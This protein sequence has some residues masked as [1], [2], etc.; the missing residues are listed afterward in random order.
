MPK[1][2]VIVP[3]YNTEKYLRECINSI[4]A[5]TFTDFELI[6]V[7]DGST[8]G[9][10][11][12]CDEYAGKDNRIRVIHQENGGVT[13]ARKNGAVHAKS[14]Y[15]TY[16]DS[17]DWIDPE[18][19]HDLMLHLETQ[20]ADM[21]IFAMVLERKQPV[22][23][24][25]YVEN[26]FYSKESLRKTV[27]PNMLFDY[28]LNCSGVIASLC[29]KIIRRDILFEAIM[30][31]PDSL[32]YGEDAVAGYMCVLNAASIYFCNKPYY[33]YRENLTSISHAEHSVMAARI[34]ALDCE[35]RSRFSKFDTD[36]S[37][38][39]DGHIA[40]HTV[41]LVR[42][43]LIYSKDKTLRKRC[44]AVRSFCEQPQIACALEKAYPKIQNR[45][46]KI[47]VLL[48]KCRMFRILYLLFRKV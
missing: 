26:G 14:D 3:I 15:I 11:A 35:M 47:K 40:R 9:S 23:I 30:T 24:T 13:R 6:L 12:I 42:S 19:Y 44:Y 10:G 21:G 41:E 29:N 45:K 46:E 48:I 4:L 7:D 37:N 36:M 28:T 2:S 43:E 27:Y 32:G 33:H 18:A 25:N 34:L 8:D 31:I 22:V 20:N 39:I 5:Q 16:V 1:L 17:D 38:Q